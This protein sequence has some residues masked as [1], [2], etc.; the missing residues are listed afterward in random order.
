MLFFSRIAQVTARFRK[1]GVRSFSEH[2]L[3]RRFIKHRLRQKLLQPAVLILQGLQFARIRHLRPA[4]ARS[5]L[6]E[7]LKLAVELEC[8]H[9]TLGDEWR[10]PRLQ[11]SY[12]LSDR[13][14]PRQRVYSRELGP[15]E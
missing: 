6:V 11:S 5:P 13:S 14:I 7:L 10:Q 3:Q 2:L 8:T 4:I 1:P 15:P 9:A 12:P